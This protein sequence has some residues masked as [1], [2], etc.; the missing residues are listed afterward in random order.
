MKS[1]SLI[2][3]LIL[4]VGYLT[5]AQAVSDAE[6]EAQLK[7]IEERCKIYITKFY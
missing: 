6:Q 5:S 4:M 3:C 7:G 1:L 2:V